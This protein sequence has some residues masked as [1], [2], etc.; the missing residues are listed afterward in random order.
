MRA[1]CSGAEDSFNDSDSI[2]MESDVSDDEIEPEPPLVVQE[3]AAERQKNR[4]NTALSQGKLK[5][6]R[7]HVFTHLHLYSRRP[8]PGFCA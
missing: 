5:E 3:T 6:A 7:R 2:T 1:P 8:P 4:G